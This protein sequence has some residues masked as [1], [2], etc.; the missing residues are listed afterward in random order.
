MKSLRI[1]RATPPRPSQRCG[2]DRLGVPSR[3]GLPLG[4]QAPQPAT[5]L[6]AKVHPGRVSGT[7]LPPE[8][9]YIAPRSTKN[10]SLGANIPQNSD[11]DA[12]ANHP[13]HP[14]STENLIKPLFFH[15]FSIVFAIQTIC[16]TDPKMMQK[17]T[18]SRSSWPS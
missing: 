9:H 5:Q 4:P 10:R 3:P 18:Q 6:P 7:S 14:K 11:Q 16:K 8:C 17:S 12:P 2:A 15:G 1:T 13:K